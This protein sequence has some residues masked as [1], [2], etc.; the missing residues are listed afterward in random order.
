MLC[1]TTS[2]HTMLP[3]HFSKLTALSWPELRDLLRFVQRRLEQAR[4]QQVAGN[5]TFTTVLALVPLLTIALAVFTMFPQFGTL[6]KMLDGYFTQM[7]IPK[8]I[9]ATILGYLTTFASKAARLSLVGAVGLLFG[10]VSMVKMM[11]TS[12]NQ[13]WR[14]REQRPFIQRYSL[15]LL[16][17]VLGPVVLGVSLTMT[18]Y[19]YIASGGTIRHPTLAY[20]A[21]SALLAILWTTG[22]FT[23]LYMVLPNRIVRWREAACGGLFAAISLEIVKRVFAAFIVT[24]PTYRAVYGALAAVPIFLLWIYLSWLITLAGAAIS[25]A[26]HF[27]WYGRWRY[28]ATPGSAFL[29]AVGIL[30]VLFNLNRANDSSGIDE[31]GIRATTGLGMEEISS[32]L[33]TMQ[34]AGWVGWVGTDVPRYAKQLDQI[35]TQRVHHWVLLV[36]PE[37]LTLANVYRAFVFDV[38]DDNALA[39]QVREMIDKGLS[40]TLAVHFDR[41]QASA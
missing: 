27:I 34:R 36:D 10:A 33:Q 12:F 31:S 17:A 5:L 26:L 32:L 18:S 7:M 16:I 41:A 13:I 23:L 37:E 1:L 35:R 3:R 11:E 39:R 20:S 24:A 14:V 38:P 2:S 8:Q 15:Y 21:L 4:L 40:D 19:I 25:A 6:H 28:Q 30:R 9:S 22:S 29:D